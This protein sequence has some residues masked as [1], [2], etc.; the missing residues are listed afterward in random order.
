[1]A[2]PPSK[3]VKNLILQKKIDAVLA[4]GVPFISQQSVRGR[5]MVIGSTCCA[6]KLAEAK[7]EHPRWRNWDCVCPD[8]APD[9]ISRIEKIYDR[10]LR[11]DHQKGKV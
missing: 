5:G 8:C 3:E 9:L 11:P 1:M 10:H 2:H 4:S 7:K 6:K